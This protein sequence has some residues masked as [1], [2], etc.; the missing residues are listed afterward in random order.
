[1]ARRLWRQVRRFWEY[2]GTSPNALER[3]LLRDI[4]LLRRESQDS[5]GLTSE[6]LVRAERLSQL[7]LA[8]DKLK[9][10]YRTKRL[11]T[12]ML[13]L[14]PIAIILAAFVHERSAHAVLQ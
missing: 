3:T 5:F 8:S 13:W 11:V 2:L 6:R 1:M 4:E 7:L 14:V 9:V 12:H 10:G